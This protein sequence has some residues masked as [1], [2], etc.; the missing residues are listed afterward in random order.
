LNLDR[1]VSVK[2]KIA[3]PQEPQKPYS[4][5]SE[6][7]RFDNKKDALT[8]AGTLT[9]PS[10]TGKFPAV[11]LITGSGAQNRDEE[12]A[13]HKPFLVLSDYLTKNGIA[14]LR[15]DDRGYGGSTG[16]FTSATTEDFTGDVRSAIDYLKTRPEIDL[17]KIGLIGHSEGGIIAPMVAAD[18]KDV[19]YVVMLAGPGIPGDE[20]LSKQS[21]LIGKANGLSDSVLTNGDIVNRKI[22]RVLKS[23]A[24]IEEVRKELTL[25]MEDALSKMPSAQQPPADRRSAVIAE[26]VNAIATP[27]FRFFVNYDP[28]P[29]LEKVKCPVLALNGAKDLQVPP[30]EN[31]EAIQKALTKAG[32]KNFMVR[33]LP[34]LNHLFQ[35]STTG[36]PSEYAVIEQTISPSALKEITDWVKVQVTK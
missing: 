32:N 8:L 7:I 29:V 21:W 5:Y 4:Y 11:I 28:V 1:N 26:K 12:L 34:E 19:S 30:E 25:I 22:H 2:A 17:K 23:R 36:S 9:L 24:S 35:E 13:G 10:K 6:D 20:I 15:Y 33:E 3:R 27:W 18:S 31:L 16:N 14:V